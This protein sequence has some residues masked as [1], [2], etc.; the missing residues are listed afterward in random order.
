MGF[1]ADMVR[2]VLLGALRIP[3]EAVSRAG[4][5]E[6][7]PARPHLP[8]MRAMGAIARAAGFVRGLTAGR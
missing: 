1:D 4:I 5:E 6:L 8:G 7:L 2:M 3:Q